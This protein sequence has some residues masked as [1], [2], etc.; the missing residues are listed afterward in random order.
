M[1]SG[2]PEV[3]VVVVVAAAASSSVSVSAMFVWTNCALVWDSMCGLC[4]VA[5]WMMCEMGWRLEWLEEEIF[6]WA[7]SQLGEK[8]FWSREASPK[9]P[10]KVVVEL[11][12]MSRPIGVYP[13][14]G[15]ESIRA[16]PRWPDDPVT[17]TVSGRRGGVDEVMMLGRLGWEM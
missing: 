15:R 9:D 17:R 3:A 1:S 13:Y 5:Q 7:R 11:G 6:G 12:L 8:R 2:S 4:S 14:E 10:M 16:R